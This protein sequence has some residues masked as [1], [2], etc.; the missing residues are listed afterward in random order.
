MV[1]AMIYFHVLKERYMTRGIERQTPMSLKEIQAVV[2]QRRKERNE[3]ERKDPKLARELGLSPEKTTFLYSKDNG[4]VRGVSTNDGS[5]DY[6]PGFG[7]L[8]RGELFLTKF[9][10]KSKA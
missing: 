8:I 6:D 2:A 4:Q 3:G 5:W 7:K 1:F 9:K 10:K